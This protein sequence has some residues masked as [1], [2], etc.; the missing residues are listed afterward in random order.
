MRG[1][2]MQV[3][4]VDSSL[5]LASIEAFIL[6]LDLDACHDV[7]ETSS[8][9]MTISQIY[10]RQ[11][12]AP[13][14][15]CIII[16]WHLDCAVS[17][18]T[19]GLIN[20]GIG[21]KSS[22][23]IEADHLYWHL[24]WSTFYIS[25]FT[26]G[27]GFVIVPLLKKKFADEY[28]WID[29]DEMID[30]AAIAQSAPGALAVNASMLVGYRVAGIPGML[31]SIIATILPPFILL[32]IISVFYDAFRSNPIIAALLK[33][34]AADVAAVIIDVVIDLGKKEI[35][36]KSPL[37]IVIMVVAFCITFFT[38]V[39]VVFVILACIAIGVIRVLF[40]KHHTPRKRP[41]KH[42]PGG[43]DT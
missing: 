13:Q 31:V 43:E 3:T 42:A 20:L 36:K 6:K 24:F 35:D 7:A 12:G 41:P 34:M 10:H 19:Y 40:S 37:S 14:I 2:A 16:T 32:S 23:R 1:H 28:H 17:R 21:V 5:C 33:G 11:G 22:K 9:K 18:F 38:D 29:E 25:A 8:A 26:V 15:R 27:G 39:N 30:L 4:K